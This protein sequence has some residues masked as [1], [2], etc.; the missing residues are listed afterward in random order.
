MIYLDNAA[1]TYPKPDCVYDALDY[2]NRNLSFNAGRGSY[3]QAKE[4]ADMIYETRKTV[5]SLVDASSEQ[6]VFESSATEALNIIINGL[7][8]RKGDTVYISP[9][10]H[11]AVV[12]PLY[13]LKDKIGINIL[14]LPFDKKT[15]DID[16]SKMNDM[17][18]VHKPKACF[19][20]QISNVTGYILPVGVIFA[21]SKKYN[22]INI[23]DCSQSLGVL[24]PAHKN[25][26]FIVFAGHKSLYTSFGVAGFIN[27]GNVILQITKSGGT[28]SDSL[29]PKMPEKGYNRYEAGS[30]NSVA[31]FGLLNSIRWLK[32]NDV[33]SNES[34]LSYY[35]YKELKSISKV[36]LYTPEPYKDL[37]GILSLNV[38]GYSA[39][40]VG[41]ILSDEF[42]I[43]VRTGY[44]CAPLIHEFLNSKENGGTVR[45]SFGAFNTR[46]DV[47]AL[48]LALKTL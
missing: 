9:F 24:N 29:N 16:S 13:N 45:I 25:V 30:A 11:N 36:H 41:S 20:S 31:I 15:W 3:K 27:T 34:S 12:R 48:C 46:S 18:T 2:A 35:C 38:E 43:C 26:D 8:L 32:S 7:D 42:D 33:Y 5:A 4:V 44:H 23:L 22:C 14:I 19:L 1:T 6:V 28:G 17:F 40:D 47:D 21:E 37:M 39:E 10:E